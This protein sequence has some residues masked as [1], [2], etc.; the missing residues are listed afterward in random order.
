M[1][2]GRMTLATRRKEPSGP[3]QPQRVCLNTSLALSP[4][5]APLTAST[6]AM[7]RYPAESPLCSDSDDTNCRYGWV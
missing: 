6:S 1:R 3:Q 5:C 4:C 7:T 2:I